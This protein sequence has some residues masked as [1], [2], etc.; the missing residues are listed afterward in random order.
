MVNSSKENFRRVSVKVIENAIYEGIVN[1]SHKLPEDIKKALKDD[2]VKETDQRGKYILNQLIKNYEIA[3]KE[4]IPLCQD[5]GSIELFLEIGQD[6]YLTDGYIL[7]AVNKAISRATLDKYLRNSLV[8]DPISRK[9]NADNTPSVIHIEYAR[10]NRVKLYIMS[11]GGGA[12]N[13]SMA[14]MLPL[15]FAD[16]DKLKEIII[17]W[18]KKNAAK[19]CPPIIVGIG[20][21]G[22]FDYVSVLA[23]KALLRKIG[24]RNKT[25]F[26]NKFEKE[27]YAEINKL[28]I[29]PMGLGGRTTSLAVFIEHYPTHITSLPLAINL[30]C[31]S[32]RVIKIVI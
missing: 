21:G 18:V 8:Q 20:L 29:G 3:Y 9:P 30:D 2:Y 26:Y 24:S 12:E 19:A 14:K 10:G 23:K 22:T 32:H 13:M 5:T 11:K 31:H 28:N 7:S 6:V 4:R 16:K 27:L 17:D 25:E 15:K 1:I